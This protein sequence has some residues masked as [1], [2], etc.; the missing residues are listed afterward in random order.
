MSSMQGGGGGAGGSSGAI[1]VAG[2]SGSGGDGGASGV[3][4][5]AGQTPGGEPAAGGSAGAP[6]VDPEVP[7]GFVPALVGVGYGGI[8]IVSRDGGKTWGSRAS[9]STNGGDDEDLLRA[10]VY[11]KGRWLATGWKLVTSDDGKTWTDHGLIQRTKILPCNIV[12]GLAYTA[13]WFYAAC[14]GEPSRTYRSEDGLV[15]QEHGAIGDTAGHLYLAHRCGVFVAYGDT[16]VSYESDDALTFRA[17]SGI[18]SAT[19]CEQAWKSRE[20]CH[21]AA[22]FEGVYLRPDWQ[23]K[24]SRSE[25][26]VAWTT[27]YD[28]DQ[29][30]TLYQPRAIAAGYVAP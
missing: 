4:S 24:I 14:S 13:G 21:D 15:W 25:D 12:E 16:M 26:G 17:L 19:Y 10:V 30:N 9:F 3:G 8:R 5:T 28:D 7:S 18:V 6:P 2:G 29:R 1:V 27:T 22:W 23:G 20:D 11:G